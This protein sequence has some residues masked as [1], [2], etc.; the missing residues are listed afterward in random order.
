MEKGLFGRFPGNRLRILPMLPCVIFILAGCAKNGG[1]CFSTNGTIVQEVRNLP[2]FT[3][4]DIQNNVDLVLST[5]TGTRVTVEAGQN[6]IGGI[7]TKVDGGTLVI[8]NNNKCNWMRD[9]SKQIK[10]YIATDKIWKVLY[11]G[12][13]N[14]TSTGVLKQDSINVEVWGG[15]GTIDLNMDVRLGI[16]SLNMG[17]VDFHLHGLAGTTSVFSGDYGLYD[18]RDLKTYYTYIT[19]KG[20][21]DCYVQAMIDLE[22]TIASIGNI[23]YAG[24]PQSFKIKVTGT[25]QLL[26]L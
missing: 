11:N 23:Y 7:S 13:G 26:P 20:T 14:I 2:A 18:A 21:N 25:G 15:C 3:R 12:S 9:Y 24:K 1:V 16:F 6:I 22:A 5:D 10:V 8:R 17:T 4:V 19:N